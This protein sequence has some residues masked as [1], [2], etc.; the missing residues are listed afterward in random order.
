MRIAYVSLAALCQSVCQSKSCVA[1]TEARIALEE[2]PK[3]GTSRACALESAS[4]CMPLEEL[5][6]ACA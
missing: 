1:P 5:V 3:T 4:A 6:L 2:N